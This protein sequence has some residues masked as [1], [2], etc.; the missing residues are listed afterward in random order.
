MQVA[1]STCNIKVD[2]WTIFNF[3]ELLFLFKLTTVF[4]LGSDDCFLKD[5]ILMHWTG[6]SQIII[7]KKYNRP[8]PP[9]LHLNLKTKQTQPAVILNY[10]LQSSHQH[11]Q[12]ELP[13]KKDT[14]QTRHSSAHQGDSSQYYKEACW[15]LLAIRNHG[16]IFFWRK[17]SLYILSK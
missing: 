17:L 3:F 9:N 1:K 7:I 10:I 2:F 6:Q 14:S 11:A 8:T 4:F 13:G 16:L 12:K 5:H 15:Q